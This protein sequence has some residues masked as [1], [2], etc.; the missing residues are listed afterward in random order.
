M[1]DP[2]KDSSHKEEYK[3]YADKTSLSQFPNIPV[4]KIEHGFLVINCDPLIRFGGCNRPIE[5]DREGHDQSR[6]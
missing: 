6:D 3:Y 1:V 5:A 2:D 4:I